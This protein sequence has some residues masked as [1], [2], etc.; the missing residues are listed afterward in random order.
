MHTLWWRWQHS[1]GHFYQEHRLSFRVIY[2]IKT[3]CEFAKLY[4][5]RYHAI[6]WEMT[7]GSQIMWYGMIGVRTRSQKHHGFYFRRKEYVWRQLK[8]LQKNPVYLLPDPLKPDW[9]ENSSMLHNGFYGKC[10]LHL[11]WRWFHRI[12]SLWHQRSLRSKT[13]WSIGRPQRGG[14]IY[15]AHGTWIIKAAGE[16]IFEV[17][18]NK[19]RCDQPN[20]PKNVLK[21]KNRKYS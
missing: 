18:S 5:D 13:I 21:K 12:S 2:R 19:R 3:V 11:A 1:L 14:E 6:A 15:G 10:G 8:V 4:C 17:S 16:H 20:M 7:G 9:S